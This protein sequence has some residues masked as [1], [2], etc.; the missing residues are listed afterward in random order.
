MTRIAKPEFGR[1]HYRP[2][3][4]PQLDDDAPL[5]WRQRIDWLVVSLVAFVFLICFVW[6]F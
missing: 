2:A 3:P 4:I 6:L 1:R 5:E